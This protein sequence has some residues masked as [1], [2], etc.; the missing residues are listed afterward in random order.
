MDASLFWAFHAELPR[1]PPT[2]L[3][4]YA[5]QF[6]FEHLYMPLN[7][8]SRTTDMSVSFPVWGLF[9]HLTCGWLVLPFLP[10]VP[11]EVG[12]MLPRTGRSGKAYGCGL[13][14]PTQLDLTC[15]TALRNR[16]G[17]GCASPFLP[18]ES[19]HHV[20]VPLGSLRGGLE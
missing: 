6:S 17:A 3:T 10:V 7:R 5:P 11:L 9:S 18:E 12:F 16:S 8:S 19:S 13:T 20:I 15:G 14:P 1:V 2:L 4:S